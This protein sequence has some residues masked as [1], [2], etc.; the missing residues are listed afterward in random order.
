MAS[1]GKGN[2]PETADLWSAPAAGRWP[3]R[4]AATAAAVV[5]RATN[6]KVKNHSPPEVERLSLFLNSVAATRQ[7]AAPAP[8]SMHA[9]LESD[10]LANATPRGTRRAQAFRHAPCARRSVRTLRYR[11]A[12]HTG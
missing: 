7:S 5:P 10:R 6:Q 3:V 11:W 9:A 12:C 4:K 8:S 2:A 1:G